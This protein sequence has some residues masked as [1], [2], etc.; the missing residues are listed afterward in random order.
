MPAAVYSCDAQG[1]INFYNDAAVKIWG[2]EPEL[3]KEQ[4]CG[5]LKMFKPDG[6]PLPHD[7]C[8]MAIAI[9][10]GRI[11]PGEEVIIERP[12][13]SRSVVRVYP[14]PEFGLSGEITGAINMGFDVTEQVNARNKMEES[15]KKFR[16][17]AEL[18]PQK[19]WTSDAVGNKDYFNKTLLDYVGL[20]SEELK[21]SGWEKMIHPEDWKRNEKCVAA[22]SCN[23]KRL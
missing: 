11:V 14:Q 22:I 5:S 2:R 23:R 21:A 19:I 10:E 12:D 3:G 9:K 4:W 8:P 18:M 16:L 15:E 13:G 6:S 7:S 20:S 17:I 1:H